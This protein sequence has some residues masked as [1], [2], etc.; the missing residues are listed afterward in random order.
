MLDYIPKY[1]TNKAIT[2]YV[3]ALLIVSLVFFS[4]TMSILWW[5]FGIIEVV[6][7]F[8]FSN[9]LTRKWGNIYPARFQKKIF[10]TAIIIRVVWVFFSYVLYTIMT[11]QPFEFSV[12]DAKMYQRLGEALAE[13]GFGN[14]ENVFW[15]M[16]VSDR[17]YGTYL[18]VLYMVVGNSI[19]IARLIKALLGAWMCVLI[20][21]LATRN[22]GEEVGRMA[23]IFCMLMP[24]LI[25]YSGLHLKEAEMLFLTVLFIERADSLIRVHKYTLL[26]VIPTLLIGG[27]LFFFR[28]VLGATAMFSLFTALIF[29]SR[30]VLTMSKKVVIIGWVVVALTF[31]AGSTII[32]EVEEIW[33][34]RFENQET[35]LEY[36][37]KREG[38]NAF[39]KYASKSVFV[40]FIFIIPFPTMVDVAH[41]QNQQLLHGGYVVKN[42][43]A[44]FVLFA[45]FFIIKE[46]KWRDNIMI[47]SFTVA[48]L[49]VVALSAF[50]QSER[51]HLPALP[52]LLILAAYGL[53]N[54]SNNEKKYFNWYLILLFFIFIAW[55]WFKMAGRG[56]A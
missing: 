6:G 26:T 5:L 16:P 17:G 12:G 19:I 29:S 53:S 22:F 40:P 39:A 36:R 28:T 44:F 15:G 33:E 10:L 2:L 24:N 4:Y 49:I 32:N 31:F 7:F 47:T 9:I 46:K 20:Y 43:M 25:Y 52:F 13:T 34:S 35:S 11:G 45:L 14:Y 51:F 38:G 42:V 41:Q 23:A 18:G 1:F 3:I 30:R 8:Y 54:I 50:A 21:R 48:Y 56:L 27:S 37:S 55:N